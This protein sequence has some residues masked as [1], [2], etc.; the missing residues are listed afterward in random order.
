MTKASIRANESETDNALMQAKISRA[1]SRLSALKIELEEN[2]AALA[3]A[4][5][6]HTEHL[7]NLTKASNRANES[8]TENALMQA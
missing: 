2:E 8:E 3:N 4:T 1:N 5:K 6:G 7:Q